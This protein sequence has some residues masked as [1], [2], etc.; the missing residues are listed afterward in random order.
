ML[1]VQTLRCAEWP[2]GGSATKLRWKSQISG[3]EMILFV[4]ELVKKRKKKTFPLIFVV[5]I[6]QSKQGFL[7]VCQPKQIRD[8]LGSGD[9]CFSVQK[10]NNFLLFP[11]TS[12]AFGLFLWDS[13]QQRATKKKY[14][15]HIL[16]LQKYILDCFMGTREQQQFSLT[17]MLGAIEKI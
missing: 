3:N 1:A 8:S 5:L 10:D 4:S 13:E 9:S 12:P 17:F 7:R 2:Q 14:Q 11:P 16:H 6:L 15:L